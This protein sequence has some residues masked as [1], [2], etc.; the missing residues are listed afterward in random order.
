MSPEARTHLEHEFAPREDRTRIRDQERLESAAG[1]P[2][3]ARARAYFRRPIALVDLDCPNVVVVAAAVANHAPEEDATPAGFRRARSKAE[4]ILE[5]RKTGEEG[6]LLR[7][8]DAAG[9]CRGCAVDAR[10]D[11]LRAA[12]VGDVQDERIG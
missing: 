2:A 3:P 1:V 8:I 11:H 4:V 5:E 12:L 10:A 7:A 9:G 6:A